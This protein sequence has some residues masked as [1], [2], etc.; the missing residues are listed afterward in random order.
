MRISIVRIYTNIIG[1]HTDNV[2]QFYAIRNERH[3]DMID[4]TSRYTNPLRHGLN[5]NRILSCRKNNCHYKKICYMENEMPNIAY[6]APCLIESTKALAM[7]EEYSADLRCI[8]DTDQRTRLVNEL[9]LLGLLKLRCE[10]AIAL[11]AGIYTRG[12]G[13]RKTTSP[14]LYRYYN[15]ISARYIKLLL[16]AKDLTSAASP[17]D[18]EKYQSQ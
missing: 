5:T 15:A 13:G 16:K 12:V 6:G 3:W 7:T 8:C 10:N 18:L 11:D 17:L 4:R 14:P 2:R 1:R 9:T